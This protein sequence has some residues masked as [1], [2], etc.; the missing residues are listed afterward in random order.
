MTSGLS[1]KCKAKLAR[2]SAFC[3]SNGELTNTA[4]AVKRSV[5]LSQA[6]N[7]SSVAARTSGLP[8]SIRY[9][10]A[11]FCRARRAKCSASATYGVCLDRSR[12]AW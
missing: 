8:L 11:M 2:A 10:S 12:L 3:S 1:M 6:S 7:C 4:S 5:M 9:D